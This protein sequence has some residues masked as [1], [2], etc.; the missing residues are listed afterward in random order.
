MPSDAPERIEWVDAYK[1]LA[2]VLV[3]LGHANSPLNAYIYLF[4]VAAFF[5]ISGFTTSAQTKPFSR[6][7]ATRAMRLLVPFYAVNLLLIAVKALV[8]LV[9]LG[10]WLFTDP[11]PPHLVPQAIGALLRSS[12]T[13]DL[14]GAT[15]FLPVLFVAS[16]AADLVLRAARLAAR[17]G[18]TVE[19]LVLTVGTAG[20]LGLGV[21]LRAHEV[22]VSWWSLDLVPFAT[23]FLLTGALCRRL[24]ILDREIDPMWALP[25]GLAAMFY[26]ARLRFALVD[27]PSRAFDAFPWP[28]LIS[29][30]SGIYLTYLL[31]LALGRWRTISRALAYI[32][33]NTLPILFFHFAA[34]RVV[35]VILW[36]AKLAPL[37]QLSH[38]TPIASSWLSLPICAAAILASL[39][40]AVLVEKLPGSWV[41]LGRPKRERA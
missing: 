10:P 8:S 12:N 18:P 38:L 32:G 24:E 6:F 27:W 16:L 15:W 37:G 1:G 26:F 33:R 3:V 25:L 5:F 20:A 35:F 22:T 28:G 19:V 34:F 23:F 17:R 4:Q 41:L 7:V 14:G 40:L 36:I 11:L 2:I 29:T 9:G 13:S 30:F 39:G 21:V 31:S